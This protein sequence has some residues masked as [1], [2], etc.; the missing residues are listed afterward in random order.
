MKRLIAAL[1]VGWAL[2]YATNH[3]L[4]PRAPAESKVAVQS[5]QSTDLTINSW[6][7]YL[8]HVKHLEPNN[9]A[10]TSMQ[11][12]QTQEPAASED[13]PMQLS[14]RDIIEHAEAVALEERTLQVAR[15][16]NPRASAA[17]QH[18]GSQSSLQD[19]KPNSEAVAL[20]ERT[21]RVA[22]VKNPPMAALRQHDGIQ[23]ASP[24]LNANSEVVASAERTL[25]V[26]RVQNPQTTAG[27][28]HDGIQSSS[29]DNT[30]RGEDVATAERISQEGMRPDRTT[31]HPI[32][33]RKTRGTKS[34]AYKARVAEVSVDHRPS[35]S[36]DSAHQR[37]GLGLFI[38][39]PPGF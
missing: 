4:L 24:D 17:Y 20:E 8:P 19:L 2:I 35:G 31:A 12:R 14:S 22:R 6:G 7:P 38:F 3:L 32:T 13:G 36:L 37:R 11:S 29:R 28:Q 25:Q 18:D 30:V 21:L 9:T 5:E 10:E 33:S 34:G 15:V 39:A 1:V 23:L 26:A 16:G 27:R